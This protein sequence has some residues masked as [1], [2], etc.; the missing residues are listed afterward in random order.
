MLSICLVVPRVCRVLRP[1][2]WVF[3]SLRVR[4][5]RSRGQPYRTMKQK[6][7]KVAVADEDI[8]DF[9]ASHNVGDDEEKQGGGA[10][11]AAS[12]A[13]GGADAISCRTP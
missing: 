5:R 1:L 12:V 13:S 2:G 7:A 11:A 6:T 8:E 9:F 3:A 10:G 4:V